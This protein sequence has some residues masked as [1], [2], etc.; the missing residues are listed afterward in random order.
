M[1]SQDFV[2]DDTGDLFVTPPRTVFDLEAH[3]RGVAADKAGAAVAAFFAAGEPG[4]DA[5]L[6]ALAPAD[7]RALIEAALRQLS[8]TV[9]GARLR[10]HLIDPDPGDAP[11]LMFLHDGLGCERLWRD[12]PHRLLAATGLSALLYDRQ[13]CGDS[14]PLGDGSARRDYLCR[15]ALDVVPEILDD[16]GIR[17]A[18]L[19][20]HS[21]GG[22]IAL[23]AAG[24]CPELVAGVI[25]EA[26]HL[27]REDK[28][29][30]EI[31]AQVKDF[32]EGDLRARLGRYHGAKA[33]PT[34]NRLAEIWL[35]EGAR[36]WGID[37]LV[38]RIRC[39]VLTLCGE[40]DEYFSSAQ[41]NAIAEAVP[42]PVE[43][44]EL[45]RAAHVPHHQARKA[46]LAAMAEFVKELAP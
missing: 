15:E 26:A 21:D 44:V 14:D 20:G 39:P 43:T 1:P 34:F 24:A 45:P 38:A 25:A 33:G 18:I 30:T 28:T 13:G 19:V 11:T 46:A 4:A 10:G 9:G 6:L 29:L 22:T 23:A 32:A 16:A 5:Y 41:N 31:R 8:F 37:D 2:A 40:D 36:D 12:V 27:F 7:F 35:G 17:R 42:G 3:L